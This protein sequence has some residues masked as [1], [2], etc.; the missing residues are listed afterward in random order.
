MLFSVVV[1]YFVCGL[2]LK[3][4]VP[5][6]QA[7]YWFFFL[8]IPAISLSLVSD[9]ESFNVA[10]LILIS[11][12]VYSM[13]F[14]QNYTWYPSGRDTMFETQLVSLVYK[15]GNWFPGMGTSMGPELSV[16]PA[17]HISLA[18]L[19]LVAG[20]QPYQAMFIVPWLKGI[21]S[22]LFFYLFAR[23]FLSNAKS[24][25]YASMI[26]IGCVWFV[27]FPHRE[28]FAEILF[29]GALWI[30]SNKKIGFGMKSAVILFVLSLA[31]SHHFTS[32]IFLLIVIVAYFFMKRKTAIHPLLPLTAVSLWVMFVSLPVAMGYAAN[33]FDALQ[34]M[35]L[36][37]SHEG[38][39][40]AA[41]SY[42]YTPFE[43]MLILMS[44]ILIALMALPSFLKELRSRKR[45][46]LLVT[47]FVFSG[48]LIT[49][50]CFFLL[51]TN[52][53][54]SFYRIWGFAHIALSL[55][56]ALFFWERFKSAKIRKGVFLVII[57]V[58]FASMN[59]SMLYGI[60]RWYV[61][62]TYM[63]SF[64]YSNS[65]IYTA[66]WCDSYLNG[67]IIGD[68]LAHDVIGSYGNKEISSYSFIMWYETKNN[69][70]LTNF[71][72]IILSPWD[73]VTYSDTFREPIDPFTPLPETLDIVY[74]SGDFIVY[75]NAGL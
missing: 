52:M 20:I 17:M 26:F 65:M 73:T 67:S 3:S 74:A 19:C 33:V 2:L 22:I 41:T 14:L 10:I 44:P 23:N 29:I 72:Y 38:P 68:N 28:T 57:V 53:G 30:L 39:T 70:I 50:I 6:P 58:L 37:K 43:N 8:A 71:D 12:S 61:P 11:I 9:N 21:G 15:T 45:V 55:W 27:G 32:Y 34:S 56:V 31:F 47:T 63:E 25:F 4:D 35:I 24:V 66:Q 75:H 16:H 36:L 59:L 69:D 7:L 1:G 13:Y 64:M 48:L 40:L 18:S 46:F 49:A 60:K 42:Y 5:V 54:I 51:G 62:R